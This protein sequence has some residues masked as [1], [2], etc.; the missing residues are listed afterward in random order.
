M[1]LRAR[2][3]SGGPCSYPKQLVGFLRYFPPNRNARC[4][5]RLAV[6][7][8]NQ[9]AILSALQAYACILRGR[10]P[11]GSS[12]ACCPRRVHPS[13]CTPPA[14]RAPLPPLSPSL[15]H[16]RSVRR[17]AR[18]PR[19]APSLCTFGLCCSSCRPPLE[20]HLVTA[21]WRS[22]QVSARPLVEGMGC[23]R[24]SPLESASMSTPHL[25]PRPQ[26]KA[27]LATLSSQM[28][29]AA[30]PPPPPPPPC[31]RCRRRQN[32][33]SDA[34]RAGKKRKK[35]KKRKGPSPRPSWPAF[36]A[37]AAPPSPARTV[38]GRMTTIA[39]QGKALTLS[40]VALAKHVGNK[41]L[42]TLSITRPSSYFATKAVRLL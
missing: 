35:K 23:P 21:G 28:E 22:W 15:R 13:P 25:H 26:R 29:G 7:N 38:I 20:C 1:H 8:G 11:G 16:G 30:P 18:P 24:W 9:I 42:Q 34:R 17:R 33:R 37:C 32:H 3:N 36:C 19:Q 6:F 39:S 4:Y 40:C 10:L 2:P 5:P 14:P 41:H 27:P 12:P 31:R